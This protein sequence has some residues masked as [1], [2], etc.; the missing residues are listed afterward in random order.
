[1]DT[2]Q[3]Y[4]EA[5]W[6]PA[7]DSHC[8]CTKLR[9]G[10]RSLKYIP[11]SDFTVSPGFFCD[12]APKIDE[13]MGRMFGEKV[14]A[15]NLPVDEM[16]DD[17]PMRSHKMQL[18]AENLEAMRM[19]VSEVLGFE[20]TDE[21]VKTNLTYWMTLVMG[22]GEI[23]E[24]RARAEVQPMREAS[25]S[26]LYMYVMFN[27]GLDDVETISTVFE[28]LKMEMQEKIVKGQGITPK[29]APRLLIVTAAG[30]GCPFATPEI[31]Y[32]LEASGINICVKED[33]GDTYAAAAGEEQAAIFEQATGI[34]LAAMGMLMAATTYPK[35]RIENVING[36][37]NSDLNLD[38]ILLWAYYGCRTLCGPT[39][40]IKDGIIKEL[41]P[42][43]PVSVIEVD[44]LDHRYHGI[45]QLRTRLQTFADVLHIHHAGKKS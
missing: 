12:E 7:G 5:R 37:R 21:M 19:E 1:M 20:L 38:G 13:L 31:T 14:F 15:V 6:L 26:M 9:A 11:T 27:K 8:G 34:Q 3:E 4:A 24:M 44:Y 30:G 16:F 22:L 28:L 40:L 41:G 23:I 43:E 39:N 32:E 33:Y 10:L 29:G 17:D 36:Y 35:R 18:L 2:S 42:N 45:E 25:F